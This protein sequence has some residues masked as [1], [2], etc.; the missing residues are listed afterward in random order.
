M[1]VLEAS[2]RYAIWGV[3][4]GAACGLHDSVSQQNR[5]VGADWDI[6][7]GTRGA[8]VRAFKDVGYAG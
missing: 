2:S 5:I 4:R 6:V 7:L 8:L 1:A 3:P